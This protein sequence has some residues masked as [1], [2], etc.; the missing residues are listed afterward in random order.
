MARFTK[1]AIV[2]TDESK[3]GRA[4][5]DETLAKWHLVAA[6]HVVGGKNMSQAYMT[7]YGSKN[8]S[9]ASKLFSNPRFVEIVES[10]Q[11][12]VGLDDDSVKASIEAFYLRTLLDEAEP[13]KNKLAAAQ[14]WQK[15]RGLEKAK[16]EISNE[17]D[18]LIL[19]Q[20]QQCAVAME[21]QSELRAARGRVLRAEALP[22]PDDDAAGADG[23]VEI[24][25]IPGDS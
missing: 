24:E 3:L 9:N 10:M 18:D 4:P 11:A 20:L 16:V 21:E 1:K 22:V 7:A 2:E 23:S 12:S 14:Q 17:A 8:A 6:L 15:L 5:K 25:G 13:T 19:A